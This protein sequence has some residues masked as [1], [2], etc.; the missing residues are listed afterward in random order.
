MNTRGR[1]ARADGMVR[2]AWLLCALCGACAA[3]SADEPAP[4]AE[5]VAEPSESP[6][7][8]PSLDELLGLEEAES[9][10]E[11]DRGEAVGADEQRARDL[12]RKL[13][14]QEAADALNQAVQLMDDSADRLG[15]PG[16][17]DLTTQRLQEDILRKLDQVI[18]SAQQNQGQG[19]G[20]SSGAQQQQQQSS[21]NQ[22]GKQQSG[23][24]STSGQGQGNTANMP[25]AETDATLG[26]QQLLDA[27]AWGSLPDR[28]RE[29]LQQGLSDSFSAAYRSL[30]EAYYRR[31]AEEAEG[32]R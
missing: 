27:S 4:T 26:P 16:G 14:A 2:G 6:E 22:P 8:L 9:G 23:G 3:A 20:S 30:T 21:S 15:R 5:P 25:S 19:G 32:D 17:T 13:T 7:A 11:G 28:L 29:T 12:E 24:Q 18:D 10:G 31:L 1:T